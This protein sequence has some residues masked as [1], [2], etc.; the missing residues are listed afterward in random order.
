MEKFD[1]PFS[2]LKIFYPDASIAPVTKVPSFEGG[3]LKARKTETYSSQE[4]CHA[5][6]AKHQNMEHV[7]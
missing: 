6:F 7:L 2:Q 3:W 1:E 4:E 5:L